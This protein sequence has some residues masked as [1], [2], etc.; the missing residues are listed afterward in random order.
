MLEELQKIETAEVDA[1]VEI[2]KEQQVLDGLI[3]K[4]K[5]SKGKV[6]DAV[7]ERVMRLMTPPIASVR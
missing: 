1:L 5:A 6:P 2:R 4:A 7:Y 3:E